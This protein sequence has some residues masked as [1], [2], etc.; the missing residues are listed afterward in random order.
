MARRASLTIRGR[1]PSLNEY[2]N[3]CRR[4]RYRANTMKKRETTRAAVAARG[5]RPFHK[6]VRVRFLWIEKDKRRDLDNIAFAKKFVLDGLVSAGVLENDNAAH[7]VGLRDE[8]AYDKQN[9]RVEVVI[10]ECDD[11]DNDN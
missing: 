2:I 4:N 3:A 6:P 7:V 11:N 10:E 9:P 1:F 5:V 8:F